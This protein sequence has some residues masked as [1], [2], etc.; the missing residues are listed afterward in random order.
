MRPGNGT[1]TRSVMVFAMIT[2]TGVNVALSAVMAAPAGWM[3]PID[4]VVTGVAASGSGV[5]DGVVIAVSR[6]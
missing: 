1:G 6:V 4:P 3:T 5:D 2:T